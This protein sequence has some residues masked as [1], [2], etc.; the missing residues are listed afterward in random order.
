M[1]HKKCL[2]FIL[3]FTMPVLIAFSVLTGCS[4]GEGAMG[5]PQEERVQVI[6]QGGTAFRLEV[7]DGNGLTAAWN[8]HTDETTVG[9]ALLSVGFTD[10]N[11]F[12]TD[13]NGMKADFDKDNAYWAFYIDGE[14]ATT[15]AG[16]TT[17]EPDKTY[18]FVYTKI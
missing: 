18:A 10:A 15:G 3:L 13:V 2:T 11:D 7:T 16:S 12:I 9:D 1:E 14:Y 8:V 5:Q 4:D 17:I 6:G